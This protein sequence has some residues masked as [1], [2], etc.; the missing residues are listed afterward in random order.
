MYSRDW[1]NHMKMVMEHGEIGDR[2]DVEHVYFVA[3]KMRSLGGSSFMKTSR[4]YMHTALINRH[5]LTEKT[6]V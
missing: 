6:W 4:G 5:L 2:Y 3:G 1:V